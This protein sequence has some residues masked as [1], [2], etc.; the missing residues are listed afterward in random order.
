MGEFIEELKYMC[1]ADN[2]SSRGF[3]IGITV[4]MILVAVLAVVALVLTIINAV[5]GYG[6]QPLYLI[7]LIGAI[8]I[9]IG[10]VVFLKKQ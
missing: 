6:I 7:M 8:A 9:D 2:T 3:Y 5:K 1:S 4:M 10:V